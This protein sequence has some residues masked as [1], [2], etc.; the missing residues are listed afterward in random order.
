[1]Q[2]T[3]HMSIAVEYSVAPRSTSGALRGFGWVVKLQ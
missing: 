2:P 1:M 3:D